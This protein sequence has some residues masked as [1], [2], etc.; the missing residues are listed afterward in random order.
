[1]P[2]G[3]ASRFDNLSYA[4]ASERLL[5]AVLAHPASSLLPRVGVRPGGGLGI[6]VDGVAMTATVAPGSGF[7]TDVAGG[8]SYKFVI[9]TAVVLPLTSRPGGGTSRIDEVVVV[10]KNVDVR[11]ADGTREIDLQVI[12]GTAGASPSAPTIPTGQLRLGELAVPS[13]GTILVSKPPARITGLGGTLLLASQDE[14][15]ALL[16][17]LV[18]DGLIVYREDLDLFKGRANGGWALFGGDQQVWKTGDESVTSS[19]TLQNDGSLVLPLA[20]N[21]RY[22]LDGYLAYTGPTFGAGPADL[23]AAWA[24]P[25]GATMRW[26]QHG[27]G[28]NT[29][30]GIAAVETDHATNHVLGTYGT[31]TNIV[32]RPAG[33]VTTSGTAGDLQLRWAQNVSNGVATT[34]RAGSWI[35]L[36]RVA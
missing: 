10:V 12:A 26:A 3:I 24:V 1:M 17:E 22:L 30:N 36:R 25:A 6:T 19:T 33:W 34:L 27:P 5:D 32:A 9:P 18:Y 31:G 8:G 20:A 29:P 14:E 15:D 28:S 21:A 23:K 35:R 13:S 4:G 2:D 16:S 7:V 11:P